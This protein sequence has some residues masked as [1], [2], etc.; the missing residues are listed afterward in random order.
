MLDICCL[1]SL[2]L[3]EWTFDV[4][5][6]KKEVGNLE[7]GAIIQCGQTHAKPETSITFLHAITCEVDMEGSG[8]DFDDDSRRYK[9]AGHIEYPH[10]AFQISTSA[11]VAE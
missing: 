5:T 4:D 3:E 9:I 2:K 1:N 7:V 8:G 6:E 10:P 11:S